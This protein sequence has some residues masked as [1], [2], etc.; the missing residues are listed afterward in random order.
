MSKSKRISW[1]PTFLVTED[2]QVFNTKSNRFLKSSNVGGVNL[3]YKGKRKTLTIKQI[4]L[5]TE[6]EQP[7]KLER[8]IPIFNFPDFIMSSEGRL[9]NIR[10]DKIIE[11]DDNGKVNFYNE[12]N[13]YTV[14]PEEI[15][16]YLFQPKPKPKPEPE[17]KV[18]YVQPPKRRFGN[19][20]INIILKKKI[21]APQKRPP[22]M[23]GEEYRR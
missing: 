11:P 13:V 15:M 14:D 23:S 4:A 18:I 20:D 21:N 12:K 6:I 7:Q 1:N 5:Y 2:N 9:K 22:S 8:W 10:F 16:N 19:M 3:T 17:P